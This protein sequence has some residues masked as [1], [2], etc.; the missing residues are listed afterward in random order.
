MVQRNIAR[1]RYAYM[2]ESKPY[3]QYA[4]KLLKVN[5][6]TPFYSPINLFL[7]ISCVLI[8]HIVNK[9]ER[10]SICCIK[11]ESKHGRNEITLNPVGSVLPPQTVR[12][13]AHFRTLDLT[14]IEPPATRR[15]PPPP[16]RWKARAPSRQIQAR[17]RYNLPPPRRQ[18]IQVGYA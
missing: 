17:L 8:Q 3:F 2:K 9:Y 7:S 4:H 13:V 10:L 1:T 12:S 6:F 16:P 15:Q 11:S 5:V 14:P 18:V